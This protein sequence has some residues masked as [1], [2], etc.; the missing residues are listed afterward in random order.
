MRSAVD[1]AVLRAAR[2]DGTEVRDR[3]AWRTS[4]FTFPVAEPLAGIRYA[5]TA[6]AAAARV[7]DSYIRYAREDGRTWLQIGQAL[8]LQADSDYDIA[9]GAYEHASG[10]E[11]PFHEPSFRW[12]C[13]SCGQGITDHGPYTANPWDSESGHAEGCPRFA[14]EIAR[15][16]AYCGDDQ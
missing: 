8:A 5:M 4:S 16:H 10:P 13:P 14:A 6:Q 11:R 7:A 12:D 15:Y 2:A 1:D 3:K 9:A